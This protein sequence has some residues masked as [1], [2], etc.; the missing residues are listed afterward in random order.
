MLYPIKVADIELGDPLK[1]IAGLDNYTGVQG[2]VRLHRH[3]VGYIQMPVVNGGVKAEDLIKEIIAKHYWSISGFLVQAALTS[4][5][6]KITDWINAQSA[7]PAA[8]LPFITIA[9]CTRDRT[10]DLE[11]C[12]D[13]LTQL[14]YPNFEILV[15]DNAP[16]TTATETLVR[17]KFPNA[18]YTLEPRPGLD[19]ARNR[20]IIEAKGEII[21]YTDD[22]VIVDKGWAKA[23]GILFAENSEVMASTGLVVPFELE[24]EAQVLFEEYGGFGRGFKRRWTSVERDHKMSWRLLGTGQFGTGANMAYRLSVFD[25]IG[26]FDPALDV[27]TVTNGGGDLEMFFRILKEGYT[28]VY[29]PAAMV[30]H[31]HRREYEK[32]KTQLTNNGSL[33]SYF[34]AGAKKYPDMR[35]A[36]F[37]IGRYWM[38]YWNF[39][40]YIKSFFRPGSFPR[41][42]IYA[43]LKGGFTGLTRYQ[44]SIEKVKEIEKKFGSF[45][46]LSVAG[47]SGHFINK[48]VSKGIGIRM[49]ELSEEIKPISDV[50]QYEEVKVF[51][52]YK[53]NPIGNLHISNRGQIISKSRLIEE[54]V[55][56]L[57]FKLLLLSN[58]YTKDNIWTKLKDDLALK[59]NYHAAEKPER[60]VISLPVNLSA[61]VVLCTYNRPGDLRKSLS[62]LTSQIT[63]RFYEIIVVDNCPSSALTAPVVAEFPQVILVNENR[64]GLAYA[65][66]AGII[67]SRG[68]I[69]IATDDDVTMPSDWLEK[70]LAPFSRADVMCVCGNTLPIELATRSQQLFEEYGGLGKGF[71][72]FEASGKWFNKFKYRAVPVWKLGATANAAFRASIFKDRR[73]G[74]MSEMLGPGMPSGVGEDSYLFYKILKAGYTIVYEPAA[75][76]WHKH[77]E[78]MKSL[79]NQ[80]YNY[81]KG[82]VSHH[83]TTL[84]YDKDMRALIQILYRLPQAHFQRIKMRLMGKSIYPVSMILLEIAGNLAGPW[85][86]YK[87]WRRVK[88]EGKSSFVDLPAVI[89]KKPE[90]LLPE[91]QFI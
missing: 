50:Q 12:L 15:V 60:K 68:D 21:A 3:P 32:L 91:K 36:F 59:Y 42:L 39:R 7:A 22:D 87:S 5:G 90:V 35:G 25:K 82:H 27:G 72:Y 56:K 86:L 74:L 26:L 47:S 29:E 38:R 9:V 24:S 30:R 28:L 88:K 77:R 51:I 58:E 18:R 52:S 2:I 54:V 63:N 6:N 61:S 4:A 70:I 43:E 49:I 73:I 23:F 45:P 33:Y 31:R 37:K 34:V 79:K 69:I 66:N 40:R 76:V 78:S 83:L 10:T 81:S 14:D 62:T 80:I 89:Y 44:K 67:A 71:E 1:D 48:Q 11:L 64:Q 17:S 75:Y 57:H 19:W 8:T 46:A 41:D 55:N 20:A 85:C 65:R 16:V 13:A 53:G 84:I